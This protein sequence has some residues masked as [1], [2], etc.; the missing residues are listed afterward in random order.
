MSVHGFVVWTLGLEFKVTALFRCLFSLPMGE[1]RGEAV[2]CGGDCE[3]MGMGLGFV[4]L[5]TKLQNKPTRSKYQ[6][7][8]N[9]KK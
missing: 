3:G 4:F 2:R 9:R 6:G 1:G 8:K 7:K 5:C